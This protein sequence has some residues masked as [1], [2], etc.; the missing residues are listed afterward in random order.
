MPSLGW[1]FHDRAKSFVL[2]SY[3]HTMH[4]LRNQDVSIGQILSSK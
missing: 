4:E 2:R 3:H 1:K